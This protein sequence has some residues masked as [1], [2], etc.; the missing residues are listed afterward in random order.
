M[1]W[2]CPE[3]RSGWQQP[4]PYGTH[5]AF[6]TA[7]T[8]AA[9]LASAFEAS[10]LPSPASLASSIDESLASP[11]SERDPSS[12][13]ASSAASFGRKAASRLPASRPASRV[14]ASTTSSGSSPG[15]AGSSS[16]S[17]GST[18]PPAPCPWTRIS[19]TVHAANAREA[20]KSAM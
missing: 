13:V 19:S 6:S 7:H 11:P 8:G 3:Q 1:H 4:D 16:G 9:S 10:W 12:V 15:S 18:A 14:V 17:A 2:P 5:D 20:K